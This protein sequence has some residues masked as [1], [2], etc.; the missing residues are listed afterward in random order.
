MGRRR[1]GVRRPARRHRRQRP[2]PRPPRPRRGRHHPAPHPRPRLQ[3]LRHRAA[4]RP[5]R[6]PRRP[7]RLVRRRPRL[8][9]QLRRRGQRGR[10]QAH[11]PDRP[12]PARRRRGLVPRSHHGRAGPDVQGRLPRAVR[13]PAGRRHLR[14]VRRRGRARGRR[15]RHRRRGRPRADPGG[16][17]RRR[18]VRRTT[19]PPPSGSPTTTARCCGSTRCRPASPAPA[20]GSPTS[21]SQGVQPDVVTLAKGLG[22]GI[23]IGAT[24]ALGDAATLLQPGNH[25]TTFGGNPVATRRRARRPRHDRGRRPDGRTPSPG[26]P[27]SK[28]SCASRPASSR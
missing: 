5:G 10:A 28:R 19:S 18:A 8:L 7:P 11:P 14:P 1:Q 4:G 16:G 12:H 9:Q 17:R 13:A 25:G 23:P 21:C 22:G 26:A 27:S 24:V 15:R 2:R 20:R 6:A 3:L